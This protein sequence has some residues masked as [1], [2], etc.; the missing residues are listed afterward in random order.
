MSERL[1]SE[2]AEA[3]IFEHIQELRK[4][5][6]YLIFIIVCGFFLAFIY[7]EHLISW[8]LLPLKQFQNKPLILLN[9][10]EGLIVSAKMSFWGGLV[11]TFP[12]WGF[13]VLKFIF[14]ALKPKEKELILPFFFT[15]AIAAL[16]GISL[17]IYFTIPMA[18]TYLYSFNQQLG[19]NLWSLTTYIDYTLLLLFSH[20]VFC[21]I[22]LGLLFLVH[23]GRISEQ[24]LRKKRKIFIVL[25]FVLGAILTPPDVFTQILLAVPLIFLYEFAIFYAKF[26]Q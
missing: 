13:I 1:E 3:P 2:N 14:P 10:L 6:I 23:F 16:A 24:F 4:S 26:R 17:A 7:C 18:N 22:T 15:T 21:E 9:P 12:L 25:A 20:A 19:Q 11:F 8:L 5:L